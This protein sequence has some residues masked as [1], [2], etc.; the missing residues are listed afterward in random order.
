MVCGRPSRFCLLHRTYIAPNTRGVRAAE[1]TKSRTPHHH[2][3]HPATTTTPRWRIVLLRRPTGHMRRRLMKRN[4]KM[5][6]ARCT[7][8]QGRVEGPADVSTKSAHGQ[9]QA[10][11]KPAPS[12]HQVSTKSAPSQHQASTKPAR[13]CT[14]TEGRMEGPTEVPMVANVMTLP[15]QRTM[16]PSSVT[17]PCST[18]KSGKTFRVGIFLDFVWLTTRTMHPHGACVRRARRNRIDPHRGGIER[19]GPRTC[20]VARLSGVSLGVR[21]PKQVAG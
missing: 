8:A 12:Q 3:H 7:G 17:S 13:T 16:I 9:H 4:W 2:H 21:E 10:S 11:T 1:P 20:S 5:R 14:G 18:K 6:P 15:G 19:L